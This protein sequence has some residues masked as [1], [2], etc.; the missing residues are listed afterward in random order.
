M[1]STDP[2]KARWLCLAKG[3]AQ[4]PRRGG[5]KTP[6]MWLYLT[7]VFNNVSTKFLLSFFLACI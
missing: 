1:T 6:F 7:V 2:E 5:S 4:F 3:V